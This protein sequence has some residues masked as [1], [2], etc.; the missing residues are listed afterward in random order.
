LSLKKWFTEP[1]VGQEVNRKN[2][3][4][5]QIDAIGIGLANAAAP[6]LPVFL[7]RLG[8]SN[9]QVGLLTSMPA[10]TGL[11]LAMVIG[12]YLQ[13]KSDIVP[14]FGTARLLVVLSYALTGIAPFIV[15]RQY[16][17]FA[18]LGI[19]ALAT[20][21]QTIVSILFS[22]VMNSVAGPNGRFELMSRRWSIMGS[23]TAIMVII[24]G[25]VLDR[26]GFPFNYQLVFIVLS[27]GGLVSYYFSSHLDL[28][29]RPIP[30]ISR[31]PG[32]SQQLKDYWKL[33][34]SQKPFINFALRRFVYL[35]GISLAAPLFPLYF[36]RQLNASDAW[37]GLINTTSTAVMVIGYF[38]WVRHSR[39]RG[40]RAVLLWTTCGLSFYPLLVALTNRVELV[41]VLAGLGGIF[42]A[43]VDLI[44]FDELMRTIP[45]EYSATFV[46][47]AQ[48]MLY[49]SA[50]VSPIFGTYLAD[51]IGI[52]GGLIVAGGIRLLGFVLFLTQ[53]KPAPPEVVVC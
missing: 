46:S 22:V 50:V 11:L 33:I 35:T 32:R 45:V 21:P 47:F 14:W 48:S 13:R 51:R 27:I 23:V 25:E 1:Q 12:G 36:V 39:R 38:Y 10:F 24:V 19:W 49:L 30:V 3:L 6:F 52:S 18:I 20:L 4:F 29:P 43:G 17:V 9:F 16:L 53:K 44:F 37:I 42:Q 31:H 26:L 8:A 5:V 28:P 2:F 41:V 34:Y 40:T 7:A 15:P